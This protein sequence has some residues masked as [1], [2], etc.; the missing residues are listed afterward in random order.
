MHQCQT[1]LACAELKNTVP[2]PLFLRKQMQ[3]SNSTGQLDLLTISTS[4]LQPWGFPLEHSFVT[5]L[6]NEL[7][8]TVPWPLFLRKQMQSSNSTGQL[9]LLTISTSNLQPW[10]FPLEHSFVTN[11][12][13]VAVPL[14]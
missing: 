1:G 11:L 13:K 8:N 12:H 3:S 2:W 4:N 10:G 6:H 9:D 14:C 5:N 7:K